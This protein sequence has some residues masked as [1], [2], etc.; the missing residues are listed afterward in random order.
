MRPRFP[1]PSDFENL[2]VREVPTN[3]RRYDVL[4]DDYSC[5]FVEKSGLYDGT[6]IVRVIDRRRTHCGEFHRVR[7][8]K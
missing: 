2:I 7:F 3:D 4:D 6:V 8:R 1:F 5:V